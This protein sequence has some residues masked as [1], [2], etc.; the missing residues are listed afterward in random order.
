MARYVAFL[1]AINIGGHIVKMADLRHYF[2]DA[3]FTDVETYI[4]T[5][6]VIFTAEQDDRDNLEQQI[7]THLE[8]ILGYPVATFLRT[9]P[10]L[11]AVVAHQPFP[12]AEFEAGASLYIAFLKTEP[13]P[14]I[15]N[16]ILSFTNEVDAFD[17]HGRELY[18]L[19]RKQQMQSTF[20]SALLEKT[21]GG[22]ATVRNVNTVRKMVAKY[23]STDY[24]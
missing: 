8:H 3:G 4:Q 12:A 2:M 21:I 22:P 7:E 18:W 24:Y 13:T 20:S 5:G 6:N 14:E 23:Y 16:K 11:E 17:V 1:R 9:F 19:G 15:Q 10:E